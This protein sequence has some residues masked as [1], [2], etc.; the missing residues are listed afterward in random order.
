MGADQHAEGRRVD[1]G[2]FRQIDDDV[3]AALVDGGGH[4]LLELRG[5]EEVD[6]TGDGDHMR[7]GVNGAVFDCKSYGHR[8]G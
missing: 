3:R 4:T 5:G 7:V 1:E 6:L 2:G 8:E